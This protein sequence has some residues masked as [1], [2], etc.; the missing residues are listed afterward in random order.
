M[1]ERKLDGGLGYHLINLVAAALV[2][3]G[4]VICVRGAIGAVSQIG[5]LY[6]GV[7]GSA[8]DVVRG[9]DVSEEERA[10]K[11]G[12]DARSIGFGLVPV[13][14]GSLL[15]T[16]NHAAGRRRRKRLA[17]EHPGLMK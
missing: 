9:P 11:L 3:A 15:F 5:G 1:A 2:V 6:S 13:A 12:D 4:C 10:E 16:V 7:S 17:L 14:V 8:E